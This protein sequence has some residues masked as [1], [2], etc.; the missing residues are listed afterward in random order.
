MGSGRRRLWEPS[1]P[2]YLQAVLPFE[3]GRLIIAT[4]FFSF[5]IAFQSFGSG[6]PDR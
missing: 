6:S 2:L 3:A 5:K 1:A 4:F